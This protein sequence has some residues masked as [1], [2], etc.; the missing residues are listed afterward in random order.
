MIYKIKK[1]TTYRLF[2][3]NFSELTVG[4]LNSSNKNKNK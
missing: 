2:V 1:T 4:E 3:C